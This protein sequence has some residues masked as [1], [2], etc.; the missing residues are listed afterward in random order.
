MTEGFAP[1]ESAAA[2]RFGN[3][4][5]EAHD[6]GAPDLPEASP[7]ASPQAMPRP[8]LATRTSPAEPGEGATGLHWVARLLFL[9]CLVAPL[10][11]SFFRHLPAEVAGEMFGTALISCG[12]CAGVAWLITRSTSARARGIGAFAAAI[13]ALSSTFGMIG[14]RADN[15]KDV[16]LA[17]RALSQ[18]LDEQRA[19]DQGALELPARTRLAEVP[20]ERRNGEINYLYSIVAQA[21]VTTAAILRLNR[22]FAEIDMDSVLKPERLVSADGL[23]RSRAA[24]ARFREVVKLRESVS[25]Q[26]NSRMLAVVREA[27]ISERMRASAMASF[28]QRSAS[29]TSTARALTAANLGVVEAME[30]VFDFAQRHLGH[31]RMRGNALVLPDPVALGQYRQLILAVRRAA[32]REA[33]VFKEIS[34]NRMQQLREAQE[35]V[36]RA[37]EIN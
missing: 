19:A 32:A 16:A 35:K 31:L 20:P 26:A 36:N 3:A 14:E 30:P 29:N 2:P 25:A 33:A 11:V 9:L 37:A 4:A 18:A 23:A 7:N 27:D 15:R 8:D 22:S 17:M 24:V 6:T 5:G 12:L 28:E 34:R 10:I 13:I 1:P 21:H